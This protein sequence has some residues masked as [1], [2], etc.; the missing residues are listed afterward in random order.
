M[1]LPH[2]AALL[3]VPP[4]CDEAVCDGVPG[5]EPEDWVVTSLGWN[6]HLQGG[7]DLLQTEPAGILQLFMVQLYLDD[8]KE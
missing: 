8:K 1:L 3:P 5:R 2:L 7:G 6:L 4:L